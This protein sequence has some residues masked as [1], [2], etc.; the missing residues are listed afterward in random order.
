MAAVNF[1]VRLDSR[2]EV[3]TATCIASWRGGCLGAILHFIGALIVTAASWLSGFH[4][5]PMRLAL[6]LCGSFFLHQGGA[7]LMRV[8]AQVLQVQAATAMATKQREVNAKQQAARA[9]DFEPIEDMDGELFRSPMSADPREL[10]GKATQL[11]ALVRYLAAA[12]APLVV[13]FGLLWWLPLPALYPTF[14]VLGFVPAALLVA[15]LTDVADPPPA[16]NMPINDSL[17]NGVTSDVFDDENIVNES[18]RRRGGASRSGVSWLHCA[19]M[20]VF[21][22]VL[23]C[24]Y[25][26]LF[27]LCA[28][29]AGSSYSQLASAL[30]TARA[31]AAATFWLADIA[32]VDRRLAATLSFAVLTAG[33][34]GLAFVGHNYHGKVEYECS[35]S[36]FQSSSVTLFT[37]CMSVMTIV[38]TCWLHPYCL[39]LPFQLPKPLHVSLNCH[40]A[41][42]LL[43]CAVTL[44]L[45]EGLSTGLRELIQEDYHQAIDPL[46]VTIISSGSSIGN[47]NGDKMSSTQVQK[48]QDRNRV[49]N[50]TDAARMGN[51][52]LVGG[53]GYSCGAAFLSLCT[54]G[55]GCMAVYFAAG[56]LPDTKVVAAGDEVIVHDDSDADG[57]EAVHNRRRL[58]G[59]RSLWEDL[60]AGAIETTAAYSPLV[61]KPY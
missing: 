35:I 57:D 4:G 48:Q 8:M 61:Q 16:I 41:L 33:H 44:G 30:A 50:W 49:S 13:N 42:G 24:G 23:L 52:M 60:R 17:N 43:A 37:F 25:S 47:S 34:V 12:F 46:G 21:S 7:L 20:N 26:R 1:F 51:A 27:C 40:R 38:I 29:T 36:L 56:V 5:Q 6:Y 15:W 22:E 19:A 31:V 55:I 14:S 59:G 32:I 18:T 45:G 53:L 10:A 54:A 2:W 39:R 3:C 11:Q 58:I 28:L 9:S